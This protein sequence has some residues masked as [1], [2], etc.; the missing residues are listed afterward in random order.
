MII[1]SSL[2]TEEKATVMDQPVVNPFIQTSK[3]GLYLVLATAILIVAVF[4]F[5]IVRP[6]YSSGT[7]SSILTAA[8]PT[9][10][11]DSSTSV[12][13]NVPLP[14]FSN[15]SSSVTNVISTINGS[16]GASEPTIGEGFSASTDTSANQSVGVKS[17]NTIQTA[18]QKINSIVVSAKT[19][20]KSTK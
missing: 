19:P 4:S 20:S 7:T 13:L 15:I 3:T 9:Q 11:G 17:L 14:S 5:L 16:T 2:D 10:P 12:N 6:F 8:A 18:L 1:T